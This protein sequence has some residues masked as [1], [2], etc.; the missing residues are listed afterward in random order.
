ME[1]YTA[2]MAKLPQVLK[3]FSVKRLGVVEIHFSELQMSRLQERF[4]EE[5]QATS[6]DLDVL[7]TDR[8]HFPSLE[9]TCFDVNS[10][11]SGRTQWVERLTD[12]FPR[13]A[14]QGFL[15][16]L[17]VVRNECDPSSSHSCLV[18]MR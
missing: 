16:V 7:L 12:M 5:L 6:R 4:L 14:A 11:P 3:I 15:E 13:L 9:K 8:S 2:H 1:D 10:R 18:S 17:V